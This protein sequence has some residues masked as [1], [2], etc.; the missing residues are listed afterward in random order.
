[1]G[2][3]R[4]KVGMYGGNF[5][6]PHI[7]HFKCII[8][9]ASACEKLY[10]VLSWAKGRE[11]VPMELRYRWLLNSFKHMPNIQILP[12]EDYAVSKEEYNKSDY[13][14][15]GAKAIKDKIGAPID[16]V[17]CGSDYK[18]RNRFEPLYSESRI[19][20]FDRSELPI[21]STQIR[22][23]PLKYWDYIPQIER[24]F[25]TKKILVVGSESTGKTTLV[26][27]LAL[28]YNTNYVEEVGRLTCEY[29]GGEEYMVKEDLIENLLKQ[30]IHTDEACKS[31]NR[32]LFID[33]DAITTL[34]YI[35]L[36]MD[37]ESERN[38]YTSLEQLAKSINS[39]NHWDL[40]LFIEPVN[41][42]I[43]DGTRNDEIRNN[44]EKYS[45]ELKSL[46]CKNKVNFERLSGDYNSIYDSAT[47]IISSL[48]FNNY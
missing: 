32:L 38:S 27:N 29:A 10:V 15:Q 7:G 36:L 37:N 3:Q 2:S 12:I 6:P 4:F 25:Y 18:G 30:K 26:K 39:L 11:S 41:T 33:T 9:A 1:M 46:L 14:E 16:A 13:W 47:E 20:Y 23:N 45:E 43:Q 17:F 44:R 34:F 28:T 19:V 42:F 22:S 35:R 24:G 8:K 40:V 21:S 5:D 48:F 31:S